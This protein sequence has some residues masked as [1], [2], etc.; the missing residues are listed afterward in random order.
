MAPHPPPLYECLWHG[1]NYVKWWAI[2]D[3][4]GLKNLKPRQFFFLK[5]PKK[6]LN[7]ETTIRPTH[8][9]PEEQEVAQHD[10]APVLHLLLWLV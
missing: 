3:M 9:Q 10:T 7:G 8:K 1:K 2:E 5:K 6:L 4:C